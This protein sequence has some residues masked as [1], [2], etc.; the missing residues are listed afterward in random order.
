MPFYS[1]PTGA[2]PV[3]AGDGAPTG[4]IGNV[5]DLFLDR[6]GKALYGPKEAGGWP[7][8]SPISLQ[9]TGPTG[10]SV[11][12]P[13]GNASTV[14]GPSGPPGQAGPTGATGERGSTGPASTVP[15]P[16]GPA[17]SLSIGT[18]TQGT[19]PSATLT[20][21]AGAQV[22]SLVLARGA[23]GPSGSPGATGP[24]AGLTLGNVADGGSAGASI[25]PDGVGGYLLNL[26]LPAG[27]TG[28]TGAASTVTG[29]TGA[30]GVSVTGPTGAAST[31]TGPTGA[32]GN[33]ITGPTGAASTVTG[34]T[35]PAGGG[36]FSWASVPVN[37][38]STGTAGDIAYDSSY[39]Y[40]RTS[41]LWKRT[42]LSTWGGDADFANVV[43]LMHFDGSGATFTDSS[44]DA[45]TVTAYG[46]ATQSAT[47]SKF[48]GKALYC[49]G[50]G[51]YVAVPSSADFDWSTGDCV[52]EG[53][54][55][56]SDLSKTRHL[57]GTSTSNSDGK[58]GVYVTTGGALAIGK[59]GVG[60]LA[61][62]GSKIAVN[63]WYHIA[64]V[65]HGSSAYIY[66]GGTRE[67]SGNA[68]DAWSSGSAAF[69]IGRTYQTGSGDG[70]WQGYVDDLRVT[71]GANRGYTG[72]TITVPTAAYLDY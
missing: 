60:E 47:E 55:R 13:Q 32:Q 42:A 18:V 1:L 70:D 50:T 41:T 56:V 43:L 16:T 21:P 49:D 35:G 31:V 12:G 8:G 45:R 61:T 28:S 11:T 44:A 27:P 29:P 22:L 30:T 68:S 2:S 34:P 58:T 67:A 17:T 23:T 4:G 39:L 26:T 51:D 37:S 3:L 19:T 36:S 46:D 14:T 66:I 10:P 24:I 52:I 63:T 64:F 65:K 62:A 48:G 69:Q 9:T 38:G 53:W 71:V 5:G 25:T 20:G 7:T 59:I 72:S 40:V 6:T 15:G 57:C 33:S 54:I